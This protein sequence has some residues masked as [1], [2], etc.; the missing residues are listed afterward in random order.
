MRKELAEV[1]QVLGQDGGEED[2]DIGALAM[3]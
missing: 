1:V 3:L 2:E